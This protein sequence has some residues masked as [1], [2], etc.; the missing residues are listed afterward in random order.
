MRPRQ[1]ERQSFVRRSNRFVAPMIP[2]RFLANLSAKDRQCITMIAIT[3]HN[4]ARG[5]ASTEENRNNQ[6]RSDPSKISP[7]MLF[8]FQ[9][10]CGL[11]RNQQTEGRNERKN[12]VDPLGR[13]QRH[14]D[15]TA[16]APANQ[17]KSF[18]R[19]FF[20]GSTNIPASRTKID[21]PPDGFA[22]ANNR[23]SNHEHAPGQKFVK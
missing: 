17:P 7:S 12:S 3:A 2:G 9:E 19:H 5:V 16:E 14:H 8:V 13:D 4:S 6:R 21:P 11:Q 10:M 20:E 15:K 23:Q 1:I 18:L 22:V